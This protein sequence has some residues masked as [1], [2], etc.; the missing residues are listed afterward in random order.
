MSKKKKAAVVRHPR[1]MTVID[2]IEALEKHPGELR[3]IGPTLRDVF[4]L[5]PQDDGQTL[6]IAERSIL[7]TKKSR[8]K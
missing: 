8:K 6:L 1:A 7:D 3:V 2:L 5:I 4:D